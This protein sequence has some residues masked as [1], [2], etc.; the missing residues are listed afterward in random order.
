MNGKDAL[1]MAI[2]ITDIAYQIYARAT[3]KET[4]SAI[5]AVIARLNKKK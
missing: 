2:M 5:V 1:A 4:E 3:L